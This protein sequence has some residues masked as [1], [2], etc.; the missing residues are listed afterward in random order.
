MQDKNNKAGSYTKPNGT[1]LGQR[2]SPIENVA[3]YVPGEERLLILFSSYECISLSSRCSKDCNDYTS[4]QN[5]KVYEGTLVAAAEAGVEEIYK[6]GRAQAIGALAYG[7]ESITKV[8][9][10]VGPGNIYVTLA[11]KGIWK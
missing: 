6:V 7:T 8:D 2:V 11:K 3:V 5:G 9:K 4:D 1:L 10:I